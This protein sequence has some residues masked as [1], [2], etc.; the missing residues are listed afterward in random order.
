MG[1][2]SFAKK[3]NFCNSAQN[4]TFRFLGDK[5]KKSNVM[6]VPERNEEESVNLKPFWEEELVEFGLTYTSGE[7]YH[8]DVPYFS[9][10]CKTSV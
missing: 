5:A 6:K 9:R 1:R 8:Q 7:R 4:V 3:S 10:Y 2:C